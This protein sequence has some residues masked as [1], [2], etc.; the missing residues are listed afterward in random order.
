MQF[1]Q[2]IS[3]PTKILIISNR[4]IFLKK[5]TNQTNLPRKLPISPNKTPFNSYIKYLNKNVSKT[6]NII[7]FNQFIKIIVKYEKNIS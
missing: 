7:I 6:K 4:Q 1:F 2:I 5:K 3:N